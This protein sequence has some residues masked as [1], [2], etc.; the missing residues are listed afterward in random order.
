MPSYKYAK[1]NDK[2][3]LYTKYIKEQKSINDIA[4]VVGVKSCNTVRQAL[5]RNNITVRSISDGLTCNRDNDLVINNETLEVIN[6]SLL[7]DGSLFIWNKLSDVSYPYFSKKNK[8]KTHIEYVAKILL[9]NK[10]QDY[11]SE[12]YHKKYKKYYYQLRTF[13]DKRLK[14]LFVDWYPV[15][16]NYVKRVPDNLTLTPNML[17]HWFLDDGSSYI[18]RKGAKTK[19]VIIRLCSESFSEEEQNILINKLQ[20]KFNIKGS[21]HKE[22]SGTGFRIEIKQSSASDFFNIIG[23]C[24]VPDLEYKWK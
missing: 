1:L 15:D 10:Y 16:N 5:I 8:Y 17:L 14:S 7:G 22:N 13:S 4:K 20:D 3:W 23:R 6:G 9:K 11:I 21:L 12:E 19:Q 24:P 18:R 2:N